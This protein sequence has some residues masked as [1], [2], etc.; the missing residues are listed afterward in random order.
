MHLAP[1]T[2]ALSQGI[3]KA[4]GDTKNLVVGHAVGGV[5]YATAKDFKLTTT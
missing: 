4:V 2:A 5:A 3:V 1:Q